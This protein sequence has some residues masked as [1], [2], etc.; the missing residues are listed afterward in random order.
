MTKSGIENSFK[1]LGLT[2]SSNTWYD[3]SDI[4]FQLV[5]SDAMKTKKTDKTHRYKFDFDNEVIIQKRVILDK[6]GNV[7]RDICYP[8]TEETCLNI[9]SFD[10]LMNIVPIQH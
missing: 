4:V 7:K 3:L 9:L 8:G 1:K 2:L 10:S 6:D 5:F